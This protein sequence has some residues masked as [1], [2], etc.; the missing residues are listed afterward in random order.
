M[1]RRCFPWSTNTVFVN[2][3]P[4]MLLHG[5]ILPC[6]LRRYVPAQERLSY[7]RK[8]SQGARADTEAVAVDSRDA[9]TTK[10]ATGS[11]TDTGSSTHNGGID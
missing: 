4:T 6:P 8:V 2:A 9:A 10:S 1:L 3:D 11:N 7:P 5:L